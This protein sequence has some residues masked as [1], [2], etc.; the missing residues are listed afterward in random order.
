MT[1]PEASGPAGLPTTE[2]TAD[3]ARLA[4]RCWCR[5]MERGGWRYGPEF[6]EANRVHDALVP[7]ESLSGRDVRSAM[8]GVVADELE[9]RL[10]EAID[11]ERGPGREMLLEE[12]REGLRVG[13]ALPDASHDPGP[14]GTIV[15]WKAEAGTRELSEVRV[16]W[17][18]GEVTTHHPVDRELR[19]VG[20]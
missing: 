6:D 19:R 10:A 1:G 3:I 17:D 13:C 14:L 7:F 20:W 9:D 18:D 12:M 15:G 11:Y 4:H 8:I 5:Q 2:L 16:R